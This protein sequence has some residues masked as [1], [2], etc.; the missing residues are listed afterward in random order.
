MRVSILPWFLI[1]GEIHGV[2]SPKVSAITFKKGVVVLVD[3]ASAC[4]TDACMSSVSYSGLAV[5]ETVNI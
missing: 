5:Q 4:K 1:A 2:S 3:E